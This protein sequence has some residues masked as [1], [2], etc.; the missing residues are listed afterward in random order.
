MVRA[1]AAWLR[2]LTSDEGQLEAEE[3]SLDAD[4]SGADRVADS[5]PG[6]VVDIR[7]RLRM[8][9]LLPHG[10]LCAFVAELY[11]GT[12]SVDLVWLGR[13]SIPGVEAG[14]SLRVSGRIALREGHKTIY[15]PRYHLLPVSA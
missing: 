15:N 2:R 8:V 5:V 10:G 13:R 6:S 4:A 11:D 3:L 12:G 9:Q 14:R 7:G 1:T